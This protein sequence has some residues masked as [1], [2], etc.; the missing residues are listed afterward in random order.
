MSSLTL[1]WYIPF[2]ILSALHLGAILNQQDNL[3]DFTKPLL[4]LSL[5]V[6]VGLIRPS[7]QKEILG[8]RLLSLALVFSL[9][10][11]IFLL[12]EY[13]YGL[14]F[15]FYLGLAAFLAAHIFYIVLFSNF[16]QIKISKYWSIL[17]AIYLGLFMTLLY[18]DMG[19]SLKIPVTIYGV[20][21]TLMAWYSW[22][23][24]HAITKNNLIIVM[25]SL[26]FVASDSVLAYNRF[27]FP[28]PYSGFIIMLT[29]L[30]AQFLITYGVI[31]HF[32][33]EK[34]IV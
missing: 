24:V 8:Y 22:R 21:L 33:K 2:F 10:G 27:K 5:F 18:P 4:V 30:A 1:K 9:F 29:Y 6:V 17:Y 26:L 20:V 32:A 7:S 13:R 23:S 11:D 15:M 25:G 31:R 34:Y 28:I 12:S 19:L 16:G 14:P 3:T